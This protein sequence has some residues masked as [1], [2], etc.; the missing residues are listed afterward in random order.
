[1]NRISREI[2]ERFSGMAV[3]EARVVGCLF[4]TYQG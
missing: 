2:I 1:M 4:L 3:A